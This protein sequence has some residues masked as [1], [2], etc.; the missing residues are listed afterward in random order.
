MGFDARR[1]EVDRGGPRLGRN[2][3]SRT[4]AKLTS[5]CAQAC[6]SFP[7]RWLLVG[8]R[9][10]HTAIL[11]GVER[12]KGR[13]PAFASEAAPSAT[14]SLDVFLG[15]KMREMRHK[16]SRWRA[17]WK[18]HYNLQGSALALRFSPRLMPLRTIQPPHLSPSRA[19]SFCR[20]T[21]EQ[22]TKKNVE[23]S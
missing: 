15:V 21:H 23:K 16:S 17:N 19:P 4:N 13:E 8:K 14:P 12:P 10:S 1:R 6:T 9:Y 11:G 5:P 22:A 3:K 2:R 18:P 7:W 20:H